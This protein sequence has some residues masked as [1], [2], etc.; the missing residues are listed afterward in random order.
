MPRVGY[1]LQFRSLDHYPTMIPRQV[2]YPANAEILILWPVAFLRSDR[3]ANTVQLAAWALTAAAVY[4]L[5][6]Q[7]GLRPGAALFG[8]GA[9]ALL[10]QPVLQS[11]SAHNDLVVASFLRSE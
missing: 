3:L 11:T 8:A 7:V 2:F 10:P 1:Y 4:G 9:F 6:R 5:G